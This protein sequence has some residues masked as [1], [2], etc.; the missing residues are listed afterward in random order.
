MRKRFSFLLKLRPCVSL[1][2]RKS[3]LRRRPPLRTRRMSCIERR[4]CPGPSSCGMEIPIEDG[5]QTAVNAEFYGGGIVY[6]TKEGGVFLKEID[7]RPEPLSVQLY[8]VR[9]AESG[10]GR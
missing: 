7:I 2:P 10:S 8:P 3:L 6:A 9:G 5:K 1:M 4:F